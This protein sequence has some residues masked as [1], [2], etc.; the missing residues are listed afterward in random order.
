MRRIYIVSLILLTTF[1]ACKKSDSGSSPMSIA[2][3]PLKLNNQWTYKVSDSVNNKTDTMVLKIT[4]RRTS[5]DTSW[6]YC[7]IYEH[8]SV[9]DTPVYIQTSTTISFANSSYTELSPDFLIDFPVS[10]N[11][12]WIASSL[13][14]DTAVASLLSSPVMV[15]GKNY[16]N[17]YMISR[18]FFIVDFYF[19]Q[20]IY[21]SKGIGLIAENYAIMPFGPQVRKSVELISYTLN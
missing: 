6:W 8:N 17:V 16:S 18:S 10:N 19:K 13:N 11:N 20:S 2:D 21:V 15:G 7:S 4:A 5:G 9:I 14:V 3:Y 1:A 12:T